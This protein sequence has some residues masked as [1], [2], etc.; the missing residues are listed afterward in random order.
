[1]QQSMLKS[2]LLFFVEIECN[3]DDFDR[4]FDMLDLNKSG[5][6]EWDEYLEFMV[7]LPCFK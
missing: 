7:S 3:E 5:E 6:I 1:M 2:C 4:I